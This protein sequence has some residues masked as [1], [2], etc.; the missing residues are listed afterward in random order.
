GAVTSGNQ[1]GVAESRIDFTLQ[2]FDRSKVQEWI[3]KTNEVIAKNLPIKIEQIPR[4]EALKIPDFI[5][6]KANLLQDIP[7]LRV[8]NIEGFD[9]QACGGTHVKNLGEIVG[10]ELVKVD[11][12]GKDNRRIYFRLKDKI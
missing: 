12:K 8:V 4:E 6:T 3:D 10:I 9:M 2:E 7:I 11:N 1:L 5:R